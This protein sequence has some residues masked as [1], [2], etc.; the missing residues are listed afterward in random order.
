MSELSPDEPSIAT[1]GAA[2][3]AELARGGSANVGAIPIQLA[4]TAVVA[5]PADVLL[6]LIG[7]RNVGI[8]KRHMRLLVASCLPRGICPRIA[9]PQKCQKCIVQGDRTRLLWCN[10]QAVIRHTGGD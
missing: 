2:R 7:T 5:D 9:E 6:A 3:I 10:R 1:A 4:R 8:A